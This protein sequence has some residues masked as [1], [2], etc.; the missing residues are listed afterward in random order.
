MVLFPVFLVLKLCIEEMSKNIDV[1]LI[2]YIYI[3]I[4]ML[5]N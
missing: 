4:L 2:V 3:D 5:S 1:P